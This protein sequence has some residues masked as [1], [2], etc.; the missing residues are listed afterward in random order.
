M[1]VEKH[2]YTYSIVG[3]KFLVFPLHR[4][5][6]VFFMCFC[7]VNVYEDSVFGHFGKVGVELEVSKYKK[8]VCNLCFSTY[9]KQPYFVV[10]L[11]WNFRHSENGPISSR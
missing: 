9:L 8:L 10:N 5:T 6:K 1:E 3:A 7:S 2:I 4:F 11:K